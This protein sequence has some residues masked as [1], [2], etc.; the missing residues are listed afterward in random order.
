MNARAGEIERERVGDRV[1][2]EAAHLTALADLSVA[3]EGCGFDHQAVLSA[4]ARR[5]AELVGDHCSIRLLSD[6]GKFLRSVASYDSDPEALQFFRSVLTAVPAQ[7]DEQTITKHVLGD[8][9][10][11]AISRVETAQWRASVKPE[12]WS[13]LD[14]VGPRSLLF[15]PLKL[16]GRSMGLLY[17]SRRGPDAHSYD[18]HDVKLALDL[19]E[20][21]ALTI[22]HVRLHDELLAKSRQLEREISERERTEQEIQH[23]KAAE[24]TLE[25]GRLEAEKANQAKSEFLSRMSH[26]LRTPLNAVLGFAQLL[27]MDPLTPEQHESLGYILKA[28]HHLLD[29][30]NEVLDI[31][32]IEAGRLTIA[33]EAVPLGEVTREALALIAPLAA[34]RSVRVRSETFDDD[35][36]YVLADRQRLKQVLLNLLTNAVK[37]NRAGGRV[38]LSDETQENRLRIMVTDTGPGIPSDKT[39]RL[40][41]PFERLGTLQGGVEGTGLGLA[42]SKRLMEAMGGAIGVESQVGRGSTFWIELPLAEGPGESVDRITEEVL[43][44]PV[45]VPSERTCTVLYIEDNLSNLELIERILARRPAVKLLSAMQGR[46]GLSLAR[47]HRPDLILLDIHLP[48]IPGD[49]ILHRLQADPKTR[50]IPVV[51]MSSDPTPAQ[52]EQLLAAGAHACLPK[53]VDVKELIRIVDGSLGLRIELGLSPP[54]GRTRRKR[55]TG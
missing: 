24:E 53:P 20:R 31:A 44:R 18:D 21:A 22:G 7:F 51:V 37:Y 2:R 33:P 54:S 36:P 35:G 41:I 52:I 47:E 30:I 15:V 46:L 28:G 27:E 26:E 32:R 42:L 25:H 4:A 5:I 50:L 43:V 9:Q 40:F 1:L 13:I 48:D 16:Y 45:G 29:L 17:L 12:Y 23:L 6:D 55:N 3:L 8:G 38:I 49:E 14:R 11:F 19:A 39:E 34:E 10:P